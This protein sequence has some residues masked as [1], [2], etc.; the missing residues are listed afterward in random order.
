MND[1][2]YRDDNNVLRNKLGLSDAA[3]L[4]T[5]EYQ[6][7]RIRNLELLDSLEIHKITM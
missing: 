6:L 5:V 3:E 7:T 1:N 2:P 4:H